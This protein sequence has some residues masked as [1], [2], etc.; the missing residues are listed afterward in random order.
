MCTSFP[1]FEKGTVLKY[2]S[3]PF[4][5]GGRGIL[6]CTSFPFM[7]IAFHA[8]QAGRSNMCR[9]IAKHSRKNDLLSFESLFMLAS[10]KVYFKVKS[11][12]EP[13]TLDSGH[14]PWKW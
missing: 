4:R 6:K 8:S 2:T 11:S 14:D 13:V 5:R 3:F 7:F 9:G 1:F 12:K 10:D